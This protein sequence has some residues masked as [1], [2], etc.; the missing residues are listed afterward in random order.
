MKR[1]EVKRLRELQ[2][3]D[4]QAAQWETKCEQMADELHLHGLI[5]DAI[6][7]HG[8]MSIQELAE[9]VEIDVESCTVH[10]GA[11]IKKGQL[12]SVLKPES[13]VSEVAQ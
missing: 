1:D 13:V 11:M 3:A 5:S 6:A 7:T 8:T 2:K 9:A 4:Q 12:A 10:V